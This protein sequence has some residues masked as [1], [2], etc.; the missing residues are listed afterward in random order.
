MDLP[1][2]EGERNHDPRH[3]VAHPHP[4]S[5]LVRGLIDRKGVMSTPTTFVLAAIEPIWIVIGS[6]AGIALGAVAAWL[7][8]GATTGKSIRTAR[9]EGE[10]MIEKARNEAQTEA[11]RIESE[12]E[13]KV[14]VRR[15]TV[16]QEAVTML[17][18]ARD[19]QARSAKREQTLDQKLDQL[20]RREEKLEKKENRIEDLVARREAA[21]EEATTRTEDLRNR[22]SQAASMSRE[23]ARDILLQETRQEI[24]HEAAKI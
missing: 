24:E 22:L 5:I 20:T 18:E 1:W 15:R 11:R 2:F 8:I 3:D 9:A 14:E 23:E 19:S 7:F 16:E 4:D 13:K 17:S 21:L 10:S 6:G 12:S